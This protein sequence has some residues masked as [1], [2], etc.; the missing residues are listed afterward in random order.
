[1]DKVSR[2]T[3]EVKKWGGEERVG[4]EALYQAACGYYPSLELVH[5][6]NI[7]AAE[8]VVKMTAPQIM[9]AI[10][11]QQDV[12]F[13][14]KTEPD[15]DVKLD[16]GTNDE[17]LPTNA[18]KTL[19]FAGYAI[20]DSYNYNTARVSR[21][22]QASPQFVEMDALNYT[23]YTQEV[24]DM[25]KFDKLPNTIP[26]IILDVE[27]KLRASFENI[28]SESNKSR[29]DKKALETMSKIHE[30]NEKIV[31]YFQKLVTDSK[32]TIGWKKATEW[33]GVS[34]RGVALKRRIAEQVRNVLLAPSGNFLST[35]VNLATLFQCIYV[36]DSKAKD[37]GKL[38]NRAFLVAGEAE[39]LKVKPVAVNVEASNAAGIMP[40][41]HVYVKQ[42]MCHDPNAYQ[43][44]GGVNCPT[45]G[46]DVGGTAIQIPGP[47]WWFTDLKV[48][49]EESYRKKEKGGD[50][51]EIKEV[52]EEQ[53]KT[54]EQIKEDKK[55]DITV[56]QAWGLCHYAWSAL[57]MC[58][59]EVIVPA[60]FGPTVG[61]RYRVVTESGELFTGFLRATKT[62][63]SPDSS[64]LTR[65]S[66][67]HIICPG[68]NLP[69]VDEIEAI[70]MV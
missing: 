21:S 66:F 22:G 5:V 55:Q 3:I 46:P 61:K 59:A 65:L 42:P 68:F 48:G 47:P 53:T 45:K 29:Q 2:P 49:E 20:G 25:A 17:Y 13:K 64:C 37:P 6:D 58:G 30:R 7:D 54:A 34:D 26:E 57:S 19:D 8:K 43:H 52:K 50:T 33:F 51:G 41:S 12:S 40:V 31:H 70:G 10:G 16:A 67:S 27:A 36:P 63:L 14:G 9:Q 4:V 28:K 32:E 15:V 38:V 18:D 1:M 39:E 69:G 11:K 60:C 56:S 44:N 62:T 24:K 23:I 35:L